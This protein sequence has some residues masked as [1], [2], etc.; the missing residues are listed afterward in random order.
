M[1]GLTGKS[2]TRAEG[3][4]EGM[5]DRGGMQEKVG[6]H[7]TSRVVADLAHAFTNVSH[8]A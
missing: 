4:G 8:I 1:N 5:K 3:G 2:R 7:T 6:G